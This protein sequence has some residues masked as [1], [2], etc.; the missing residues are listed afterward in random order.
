MWGGC[1]VRVLCGY[2]HRRCEISATS[3][4]FQAWGL[5][6]RTRCLMKHNWGQSVTRLS[7]GEIYPSWHRGAI[8]NRAVPMISWP[9]TG[10]RAKQWWFEKLRGHGFLYF[11]DNG[12]CFALW[13]FSKSINMAWKSK[14]SATQHNFQEMKGAGISSWW[15][16]KVIDTVCQGKGRVQP[17]GRPWKTGTFPHKKPLFSHRANFGPFHSRHHELLFGWQ[18]PATYWTNQSA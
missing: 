13:H 1:A 9:L 16:Y 18:R 11:V 5:R 17:R 12:T 2:H 8:S 14:K 4:F 15:E 3:A 10:L 6:G 7:F